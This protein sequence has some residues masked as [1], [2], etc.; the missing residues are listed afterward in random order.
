MPSSQIIV[1]ALKERDAAE[2][3][4]GGGGGGGMTN[5]SSV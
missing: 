3:V 4:S 2:R 1:R 5:L